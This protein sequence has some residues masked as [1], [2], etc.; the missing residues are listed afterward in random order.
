[1]PLSIGEFTALF[2]EF[3]QKLHCNRQT[4]SSLDLAIYDKYIVIYDNVLVIFESAIEY[5]KMTSKTK[6]LQALIWQVR[7]LFQDLSCE[8]SE[9]LQDLGIN[10]SQRA[11]LEFLS[12]Q[13]SQTV[14]DIARRFD[15]SRQHIQQLVNELLKKGLVETSHNPRH[16]RSVLIQRTAAGRTMFETIQQREAKVLK[17]MAP[18]FTLKDLETALG[19]LGQLSQMLQ[20]GYLHNTGLHTRT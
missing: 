17:Q 3:C 6:T 1:M 4:N 2:V 19:T 5:A 13:E 14:P 10:T 12:N 9:L 7:R 18:Y 16:K 15:V 20:S 8:S 11:V